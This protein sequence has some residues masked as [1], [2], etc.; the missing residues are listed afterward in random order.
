MVD[1]LQYAWW[2][3]LIVT[4][5]ALPVGLLRTVAARSGDPIQGAATPRAAAAFALTLGGIGLLCLVVLS[6]AIVVR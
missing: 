6:V 1:G 4:L 2:L 3:A 5:G